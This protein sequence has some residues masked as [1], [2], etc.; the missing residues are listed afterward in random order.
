MKKQCTKC[1]TEKDVRVFAK[2]SANTDGYYSWCKKCQHKINRKYSRDTNK[3][4]KYWETISNNPDPQKALEFSIKSLINNAKTHSK[5][6]KIPCD[7]TYEYLMDLYH[8]Q[9]GRCY[10]TNTPM[11]SK[12]IGRTKRDLFDMSIDKIIPEKGYTKENT[13]LCCLGINFLKNSHT[14]ETMMNALHT[15]CDN[16]R[17]YEKLVEPTGVEPVSGDFLLQNATSLVR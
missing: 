8:R 14:Q 12:G 11:K 13:V 3:R 15:F 17:K 5:P 7:I 2:C 4:K 10:Y 16:A 1:K 9:K 6:R